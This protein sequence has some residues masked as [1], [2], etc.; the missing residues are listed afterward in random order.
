M[1]F[2]I[3]SQPRATKHALGDCAIYGKPADLRFWFDPAVTTSTQFFIIDQSGAPIVEFQN[4]ITRKELL[5]FRMYLYL[6]YL[7]TLDEALP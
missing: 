2:P 5:E 4:K 6:V 1:I 3:Q 7:M